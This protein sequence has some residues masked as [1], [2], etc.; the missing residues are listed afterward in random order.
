MP[1]V[2]I[3]IVGSEKFREQKDNA[4]AYLTQHD[5]YCIDACK[6]WKQY[7]DGYVKTVISECQALYVCAGDKE[8]FAYIGDTTK[9]YIGFATGKGIPCYS[10]VDLGEK[11]REWVEVKSFK[12]LP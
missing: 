1:K 12:C 8:I 5:F 2:N 11:L 10:S 7:G 3:A 4:I 6:L 9:L